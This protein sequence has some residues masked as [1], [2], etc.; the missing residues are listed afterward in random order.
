MIDEDEELNPNRRDSRYYRPTPRLRERLAFDVRVDLSAGS[1][2]SDDYGN[3]EGDFQEQF[4][5]A[6]RVKPLRGGE[7]VLASRLSGVQPVV[8]Q[9]R[10]SDNTKRITTAWRARDVRK[11]THYN[12][13]S[14]TNMDERNEFFDI[15]ATSGVAV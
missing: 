3:V 7:D 15:L 13:N 14:I 8:I 1:P 5:V 6:A 2:P 12:I 9:I 10:V 4:Q 11:G